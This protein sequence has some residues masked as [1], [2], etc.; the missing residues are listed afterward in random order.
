MG[1]TCLQRGCIPTKTYLHAAQA[2]REASAYAPQ[3]L[4]A[5]N[6]GALLARKNELVDTLTGGWTPC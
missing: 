6:R 4:T 2:A 3:A 5:F 1:G